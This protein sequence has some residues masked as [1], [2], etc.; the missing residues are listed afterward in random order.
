[1]ISYVF[2]PPLCVWAIIDKCVPSFMVASACFNN[3]VYVQTILCPGITHRFL[4][5]VSLF[6]FFLFC[7]Y[8]H[9]SIYPSSVMSA[10]SVSGCSQS[11]LMAHQVVMA[12]KFSLHS[13]LY[14][15]KCVFVCSTHWLCCKISSWIDQKLWGVP[16]T[17]YM[18][19]I[20]E[21]S[22]LSPEC[23]AALGLAFLLEE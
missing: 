12:F 19:L 3:N 22:C 21:E 8:I 14:V 20:L 9:D 15:P 1:M 18:V 5:R 23:D 10:S 17:R 2:T 16:E 4:W 7:P 13:F 11:V 6:L